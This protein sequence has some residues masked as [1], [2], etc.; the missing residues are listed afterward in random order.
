MRRPQYW[1]N[2]ASI[3]P[4]ASRLRTRAQMILRATIQA[5]KMTSDR[6]SIS[7]LLCF[8]CRPDYDTDWDAE[9][10]KSRKVPEISSARRSILHLPG[11]IV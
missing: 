11:I 5:I 1:A 8:C 9:M 4:A 3:S 2:R 10:E 7:I 6:T